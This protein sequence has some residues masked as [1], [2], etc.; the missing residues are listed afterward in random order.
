[1]LWTL[2]EHNESAVK[3]SNQEDLTIVLIK[4]FDISMYGIEIT[5]LVVQCLLSLSEDNP[6]AIKKL[7]S[8]KNTIVQLLDV[9]TNNAKSSEIISLKTAVCG[10][11]MNLIDHIENN[12]MSTVCKVV[13]VLS[14]TLSTDCKQSLSTLTSILPYEKNAFSS[15]AKKKVQETRRMF[16]TQQQALEI[17]ANICSEDQENDDDTNLSDSDCEADGVDDV[18]MDDKLCKGLSSLPLEIVE[19]FDSCDI[20]KKVWSK[21]KA[22]DKD[23]LE[24]LEQSVE[25]RAVLK[26]IHTLNC[27]A[28][29][30]LNNLM[31]SLEIDALGGMENI[32]R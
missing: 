32:Y 13:N 26:Q 22:V 25:G 3:Y 5:T 15:T 8:C 19:V 12:P 6:T 30:C 17:L 11:L 27:R 9:E 14:E 18:C 7:I 4:F 31:T 23:A 16:G 10:L 29:I 28:Y 2:C 20:L 21:T 24:I 1:M